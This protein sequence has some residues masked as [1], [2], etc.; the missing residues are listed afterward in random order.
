MLNKSTAALATGFFGR[1]KKAAVIF[2]VF[3]VNILNSSKSNWIAVGLLFHEL[4]TCL[5]L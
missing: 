3:F 5:P 1:F 2:D 4:M